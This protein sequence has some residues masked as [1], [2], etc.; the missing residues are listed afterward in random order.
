MWELVA[1][2][3]LSK[4]RTQQHLERRRMRMV[5]IPIVCIVWR[6]QSHGDIYRERMVGSL[7]G[8]GFGKQEQ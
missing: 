2:A 8:S 7:L 4:V 6:C 3:R 1:A 5:G